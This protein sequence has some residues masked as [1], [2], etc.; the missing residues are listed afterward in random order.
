MPEVVQA[1]LEVAQP[2][3]PLRTLLSSADSWFLT[4]AA[5]TALA[6]LL[7]AVVVSSRIS[8]RLAA[9]AEKTAVLDL[10]RLDVDFDEGTDEVG[11]LARLLGDL[12]ARLRVSA[13][14]VREAERRATIGELARQINHDIK[15]GLIP[16][17]NVMRHLAQVERNEP[18][19]LPQV[20]A[21]RRQTV[22]SSMAYL[23]TLATSYQ[24]L[25]PPP[26]RRDCDLNALISDVVRAAQGHDRVEV[27][28]NLSNVPRVLG[29]PVAF[30]RILENL[31]ANA[32]DS[33]SPNPGRITVSTQ[34][35]AAPATA[36]SSE[37][38][39]EHEP[40]AVRVTVAD[41]GRGM[42]AEEARRIFEA[43]YT[44]KEHGTGLGL[45]IVRRLVMDF[46]GAIDVDTE[47]GK[48]TR[49]SIDIPIDTSIDARTPR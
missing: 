36:G 21:E 46:N 40:P 22:E 43:F 31:I 34:L 25:S 1:R 38:T 19:A 3:T 9:L 42:S 14:H 4:T 47:P 10:D 28:T 45:S 33:V 13:A 37:I 6:A 2:L 41:T 26:A 32:I 17:R 7:L 44:T 29:D 11:T 18:H 5:G 8:G 48:G 30:R 27:V 20:F 16:L 49:I 12:T 39:R 35:L 15:N 24:R 23:E